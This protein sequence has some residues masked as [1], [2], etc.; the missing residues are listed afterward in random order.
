MENLLKR[1]AI[2]ALAIFWL[3][4]SALIAA[5]GGST[6]IPAASPSKSRKSTNRRVVPTHRKTRQ[7][8]QDWGVRKARV[9]GTATN[10]SRP[11]IFTS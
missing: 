5:P 4:G 10:A 1:L 9:Q 2:L 6:D 7:G 11:S 8:R 3:F